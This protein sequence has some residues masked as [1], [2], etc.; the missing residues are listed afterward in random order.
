[1]LLSAAAMRS[2]G[3][4]RWGGVP[5]VLLAAA[6]LL[7]ACVTNGQQQA[8]TVQERPT[9]L[10]EQLIGLDPLDLAGAL[11]GPATTRKD[12]PAEVWQYRGQACVLD[13]FLYDG[14]RGQEVV[15][16]EARNGLARPIAP[17]TCLGAL[18]DTS[19]PPREAAAQAN[20]A[21]PLL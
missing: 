3:C 10:A 7:S 9:V 13:V 2:R 14:S 6:T 15:H 4:R 5:A 11:G 1:M 16:L 17:Q 19:D 18:E 21:A 8:A 20:E 12:H